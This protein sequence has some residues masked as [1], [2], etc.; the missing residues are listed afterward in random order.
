MDLLI[1]FYALLRKSGRCDSFGK[2]LHRKLCDDIIDDTARNIRTIIVGGN[3]RMAQQIVLHDNGR[4][5][6]VTI[7]GRLFHLASGGNKTGTLI[8][9]RMGG[10]PH[11]LIWTVFTRGAICIHQRSAGLGLQT[12]VSLTW[13]TLPI[14]PISN[15]I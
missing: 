15:K 7:C 5:T 10:S 2:N 8:F 13:C 12:V 4:L 14:P 6:G 1:E 3:S 9:T 11:E